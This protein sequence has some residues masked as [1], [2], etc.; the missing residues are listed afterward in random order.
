MIKALKQGGTLL[1]ESFLIDEM[2]E[3]IGKDEV[4]RDCYFKPNELLKNLQG[5]RILFYHEGEERGRQVVQC[6]AQK[7]LDRDVARY[8]LFDMQSGPAD[9]G[10]TAQQKLAETL[11][12]KK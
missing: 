8:A 10:P 12:K 6:L 11:F 3:P 5:M 4:W 7:P 2:K 1:V 9:K